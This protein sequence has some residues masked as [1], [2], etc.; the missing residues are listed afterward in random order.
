MGPKGCPETSVTNYQ[1]MLHN[2]PGLLSLLY[3]VGSFGLT[4]SGCGQHE[5]QYTEL[6]MN[7]NT[8]GI[9]ICGLRVFLYAL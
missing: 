8:F 3:G 6:R 4:W 7:K 2:I 5:M 9:I 1:S